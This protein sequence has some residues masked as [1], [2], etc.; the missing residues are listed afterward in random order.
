MTF[1]RT[2]AKFAQRPRRV[3]G[4]REQPRQRPQAKAEDEDQRPE[5]F[6][7]AA[8]DFQAAARQ[9]QDADRRREVARGREGQHKPADHP[10]QGGQKADQ[11]GFQKKLGPDRFA[12]EPGGKVSAASVTATDQN[13]RRLRRQ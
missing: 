6:R 3:D 5:Q 10:E 13:T 12:T 9:P 2:R 11:L 7:H 1:G 4:N 8:Q